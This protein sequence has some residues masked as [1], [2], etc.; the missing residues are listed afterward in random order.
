MIRRDRTPVVFLLAAGALAWALG[1]RAEPPVPAHAAPAALTPWAYLPVGLAGGTF[2]PPPV[3]VTPAPPTAT[4]APTRAPSPTATEPP[5]AT[6]T[7]LPSPTPT[8]A[9]YR[10]PLT[11]R[12]ALDDL[13]AGYSPSRWYETLLAVLQRRYATGHHIVTALK[14]SKAKAAQWTSGRTGSFADLV[15]GLELAVHEMNHQL[16]IQEGFLPTFGKVYF[17]QVRSD[18]AVRVNVQPTFNRSE[19][20]QYITGPLDNQYKAIYLTG[21][22][23]QQGFFTLLDEFNAYTHSLFTGYGLYDQFPPG[24]RV[25]HRDGLVTFMM[26]TQFYLR[27]ARLKHAGQYSALRA[28]PELRSLVRLLWD[29]A[30]FILNVTEPIPA[31][32]LDP[33]GVEAEMRKADMQAEVER[34]LT[35]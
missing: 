7:L 14:D 35:P 34:F 30:N 6:P 2:G 22:S 1:G 13:K 4:E 9:G 3:A 5:T 29:R 21:S 19:I 11:D 20:A 10:E 33:A 32:A 16:G 31:L 17:Y 8:E 25:S 15:S 26:Y 12:P 28:D 18:L 27:H 23:G 24:Q